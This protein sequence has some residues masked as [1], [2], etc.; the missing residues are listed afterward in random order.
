MNKL[1]KLIIGAVL[2]ATFVIW[3][4]LVK[5]VDVQPIGLSDSKVGF[6]TFNKVLLDAIDYNETLFR[7]T[8]FLM[9][10]VIECKDTN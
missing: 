8:D 1:N 9:Y 5:V 3:T 7:I 4:V 2:L 10:S 6:A